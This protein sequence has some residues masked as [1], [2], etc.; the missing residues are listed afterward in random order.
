M[1]I[2]YRAFVSPLDSPH[3]EVPITLLQIRENPG[4]GWSGEMIV[5][6][7]P[8]QGMGIAEAFG[9]FNRYRFLPGR[10]LAI[11]L[12]TGGTTD[13]AG[14]MARTWPSV[15]TRVIALDG[16]NTG[17]PH[18]ALMRISF[19]DPVSFLGTRPIWGV[20]KS[21][22]KMTPGE[23]VGGALSLAAAGDGIP[24]LA[25]ILPGCPAIQISQHVHES[26]STVPYAIAA[27]DLLSVWLF[28]ALARL[29]IRM[30][31][32][33]YANNSLGI[34]LKDLQATGE[35]IPFTIEGTAPNSFQQASIISIQHK[36][37]WH[38]RSTVLD[39]PDNPITRIGE[40]GSVGF[41]LDAADTALDDAETKSVFPIQY[42]NLNSLNLGISTTQPA[43]APGRLVALT[44]LSV[45]AVSSWQA[46]QVFHQ[47][48][49]G[50]YGN[51]ATLYV[52]DFPWRP[53]IMRHNSQAI[54]VSGTI[55]NRDTDPG[56]LV[57]RTRLG[58]IPVS[59][60][61][62]QSALS[63]APSTPDWPPVLDLLLAGQMAGGAHGFLPTH[64]QGDVCR[65][66]IR[67]AF[68]AE[69]VGFSYRD[70][71]RIGEDI[72]N[73]SLGVVVHHTNQK[74]SGL[75]FRPASDF[76]DDEEGSGH[77]DGDNETPGSEENAA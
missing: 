44:S 18:D 3:I 39:N 46:G 48:G 27:G 36:P 6:P 38:Q 34:T 62:T 23:I 65:V 53:P 64:R 76:E 61:F 43:L 19:S 50:V 32:T 66:A 73:A 68:F 42:A 70:N 69:I 20:F 45:D 54:I 1:T 47:F 12:E 30:E 15:M 10:G 5:D 13:Q 57:D 67:N 22:T 51:R 37:T 49:R 52:A 72:V 31:F 2:P 21:A 9:N 11:R 77:E 59:L 71:L 4:L 58:R 40:R 75:T 41:V 25:P 24:T 74:W 63:S 29:G 60:S 33:G 8:N 7:A 35:A 55:N 56:I 28:T 16:T 14:R 17:D 26:L